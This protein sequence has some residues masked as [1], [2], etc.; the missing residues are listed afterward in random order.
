M[1]WVT[2]SEPGKMVGK[3]NKT[4]YH[5]I[6]KGEISSR[7]NA[8]K[9]KEVQVS[10]LIK[11]FGD[12]SHGEK[13]KGNTTS[14]FEKEE[15]E[16]E[17]NRLRIENAKLQAEAKGSEKIISGLEKNLEITENDKQYFQAL[18]EDKRKNVVKKKGLFGR[19][20][21]AVADTE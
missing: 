15:L 8:Q 14:R 17:L 16:A 4:I 13:E 2:V 3:S 5:R 18:L 1:A 19:L 21:D 6:K 10:D 12:V 9:V 7:S 20:V 11:V